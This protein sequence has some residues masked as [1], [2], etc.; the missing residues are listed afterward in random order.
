MVQNVLCDLQWQDSQ[1]LAT[2]TVT[3]PEATYPTERQT[4]AETAMSEREC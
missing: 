1:A 4:L 2:H 3:R